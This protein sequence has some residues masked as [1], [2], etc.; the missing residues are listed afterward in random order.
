MTSLAKRSE[1]FEKTVRNVQKNVEKRL[2]V[3]TS[4]PVPWSCCTDE[5]RTVAWIYNRAILVLRY[6]TRRTSTGTRSILLAF[7]KMK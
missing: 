6:G 7:S 5:V 3:H 2:W 1:T 4:L